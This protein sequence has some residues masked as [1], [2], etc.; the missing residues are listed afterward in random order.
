MEAVL[1]QTP[2]SSLPS[3]TPKAR[4]RTGLALQGLTA[5]FLVF[6]SVIKLAKA[7]FVL[8]ATQ[9]IGYPEAT[10]QPIGLILLACVVLYVIPRTAVLGAVLLTGYLGGAVATHLRLEDPLLSHTLFPVYV[11]VLAWTGLYLRDTRVRTIAP[12]TARS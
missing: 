2:S 8:E 6:D 3:S 10:V 7:S 11:G 5:A 12:F 4:R 9:R 1:D